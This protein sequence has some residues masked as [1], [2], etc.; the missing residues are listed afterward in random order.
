MTRRLF[1][2]GIILGF[3]VLL[4]AQGDKSVNITGN[5]IDNMCAG[6]L[7]KGKDASEKIKKHKTSCALMPNCADKGFSV[8]ADDGKLYK[9]DEAGNKSA[10]ELLKS[11]KTT[12]GVTVVVEGTMDGETIHVT[13][14]TEAAKS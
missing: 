10:A 1:A 4:Y 13:K 3:A 7:G 9:F 11:T 12:M 2:L 5:L 6:T 14:L 8:M